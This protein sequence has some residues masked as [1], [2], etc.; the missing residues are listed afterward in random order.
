[1][2]FLSCK[3]TTWPQQLG[4]YFVLISTDELGRS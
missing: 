3:Y 2:N 4:F 1:M